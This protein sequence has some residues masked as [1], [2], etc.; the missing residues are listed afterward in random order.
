VGGLGSGQ[1]FKWLHL[2]WYQ[3]LVRGGFL[4][5]AA[6]N[7]GFG[8]NS[9]SRILASFCACSPVNRLLRVLK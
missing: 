7:D 8:G 1:T 2:G 9:P 5:A 6:D 3:V 4:A